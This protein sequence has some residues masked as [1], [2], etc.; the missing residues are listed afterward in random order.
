MFVS[1]CRRGC[2]SISLLLP[3]IVDLSREV[4]QVGKCHV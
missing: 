4:V 2:D 1:A 3:Q